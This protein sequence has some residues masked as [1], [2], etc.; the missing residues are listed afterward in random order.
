MSTKLRC[1]L[2]DDELKGL[3]L[4]KMI[5]EEIPGLEVVKAFNSPQ[6]F[7][8][9]L[10]NL[11]FDLCILDIEMPGMTGLE[12]ATHI[13]GKPIIFT[14]AYKEYAAEA[15]DLD[16]VDYVRKPI[17]RERLQQAVLKVNSRFSPKV[18]VVESLQINT[19]KGKAII[20]FDQILYINA[21]E[22]DSRDK[23]VHLQNSSALT[24]K[25]VSFEKLQQLLPEGDFVRINKRQIIAMRMVQLFSFDTI[26]STIVDGQSGFL[27]FSLSEVYR[28]EFI[29]RLKI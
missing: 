18:K 4:L 27:K 8:E 16:A 14:T 15:F 21:S 22:I 2:L 29:R 3:S 6:V 1:L 11:E 28:N 19:D 9:E 10:P 5:C 25:N 20:Q 23:T 26:T 12:V 17:T 24:I 7:L 13:K